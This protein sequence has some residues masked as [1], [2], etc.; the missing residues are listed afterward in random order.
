MDATVS[1]EK[2]SNGHRHGD[3]AQTHYEV[4]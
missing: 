4:K 2:E 3:A 1:K